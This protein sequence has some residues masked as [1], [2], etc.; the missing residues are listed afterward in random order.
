MLIFPRF[1]WNSIVVFIDRCKY[2][3]LA[4][5]FIYKNTLAALAAKIWTLEFKCERQGAIYIKNDAKNAFFQ[6]ISRIIQRKAVLL[7]RKGGNS[8]TK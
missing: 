4:L 2:A 3:I 5:I 7:Q 8:T 1:F 6:I